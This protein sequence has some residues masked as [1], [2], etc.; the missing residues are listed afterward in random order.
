MISAKSE[1]ERN[2]I[3][4]AFTLNESLVAGDY[5]LPKEMNR[6]INDLCDAVSNL[7]NK[8]PAGATEYLSKEDLAFIRKC[9]KEREECIKRLAIQ[10]GYL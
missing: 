2:I 6:A 8:Y 5:H 3:I 9:R 10:N 1:L 4:K 7:K